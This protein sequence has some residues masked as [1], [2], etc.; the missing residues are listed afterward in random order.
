MGDPEGSG[1]GRPS[2][3]VRIFSS[4]LI[5][6]TGIALTAALV[7]GIDVDG[8]VASYFW[9][10]AVFALI[11]LLLKPVIRL[12]AAPLMVVTLGL[13]SLVINGLLLALV[14]WLMDDLA[15]DGFVA[16]LSGGLAISIVALI[17]AS[18]PL[19]ADP[20]PSSSE[21]QVKHA[22]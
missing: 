3:I 12:V 11:N 10:A 20:H 18:V 6:A 22:G 17:S 16:A 13:F 4:W 7:P 9:I 15:I 5:L 19:G 2:P 1:G 21:T 8:G 14:A